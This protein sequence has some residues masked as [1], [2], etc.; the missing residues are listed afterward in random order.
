MLALPDDTP[1]GAHFSNDAAWLHDRLQHGTFVYLRHDDDADPGFAYIDLTGSFRSIT[2]ALYWCAPRTAPIEQN[3]A[4]GV[5]A[6]T[7]MEDL[8]E[9]SAPGTQ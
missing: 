1:Y 2:E 4:P 9:S 6:G 5:D 7:I 3:A 8:N